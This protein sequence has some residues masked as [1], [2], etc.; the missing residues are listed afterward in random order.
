M[1]R[2]LTSYVLPLFDRLHSFEAFEVW[3]EDPK[4]RVASDWEAFLAVVKHELGDN[5][6]AARVLEE[7]VA[8]SRAPEW[9][10]D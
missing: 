3:L 9:A 8:A 5:A 10:R 4:T 7:A 6:G 1:A 2:R